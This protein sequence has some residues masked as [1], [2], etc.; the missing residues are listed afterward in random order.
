MYTSPYFVFNGYFNNICTSHCSVITINFINLSEHSELMDS[1]ILFESLTITNSISLLRLVTCLFRSMK[2]QFISF[3]GLLKSHHGFFDILFKERAIEL[4][5]NSVE[6]D[7]KGF[8]SQRALLSY[9]E[10]RS[11]ITSC[12]S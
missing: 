12:H 4:L 5:R 1:W 6:W 7:A 2:V 11:S 8:I 10:L 9:R 3:D